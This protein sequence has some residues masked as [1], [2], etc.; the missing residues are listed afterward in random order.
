MLHVTFFALC[1]A[2]MAAP[3][4]AKSYH[5][6]YEEPAADTQNAPDAAAKPP[7]DLTA[8][9]PAEADGEAITD[10]DSEMTEQQKEDAARRSA[11]DEDARLLARTSTMVPCEAMNPVR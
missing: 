3:A 6:T 11:I 1:L 8:K 5:G 7:G 2:L 10:H 4:M 9:A